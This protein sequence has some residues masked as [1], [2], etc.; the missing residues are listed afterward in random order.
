MPND[1]GD[2]GGVE[3]YRLPGIWDYILERQQAMADQPDPRVHLVDEGPERDRL[4]EEDR[5]RCA[6]DPSYRRS[7]CT[8]P[9]N[10]LE[11]GL[12]IL[13]PR[14]S[15]DTRPIHPN[16]PPGRMSWP[17]ARVWPEIRERSAQWF[18]LHSDDRLIPVAGD[19]DPATYWA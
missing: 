6:A 3:G 16:E 12:P 15:V 5:R 8:L 9:I 14:R 19:A 11:A 1:W 7:K 17:E 13:L 4:I 2:H 18:E 10:R